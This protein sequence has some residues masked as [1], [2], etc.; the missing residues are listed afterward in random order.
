MRERSIGYEFLRE[1]L[2]TPA[3]PLNRAARVSP[4]T[5]VTTMA[6]TLAVPAS[7]APTN[8]S[9]LEHLQFAL[10]HEGMQLQAAILA[11]KHIQQRDVGIAFNASPSSAYLRQICFLWELANGTPLEGLPAAS[12]P[13]TPLFDPAKFITGPSRR[14]TRWRV[15]FNGLGTT[16]YCPTVRR[17]PEIQALLDKN[18][19]GSASTFISSLDK[20]VLDRAV[21][22]AYLSETQGSYAIENETPSHSKTEAFAALLSRAHAPEHITEEYL[23]ALQNLTVSNPLDKAVQFRTDQNWLRNA[24][25]GAMG[26]TYLPPPPDL[27]MPLMDQIMNMANMTDHGIDPLVLGSLVSF[28]FVF[29]HPFMDG[30]GRLSRFLFHKLV[31]SC[32]QL[33]NGLV[34]PISIAMKRHEEQYLQA[35]QTFSKPARDLWQVTTIDDVRIDA[36]FK[37]DASNY[38]YWDATPCVAFGLQMASEALNHDLRE[39]SEFL[40]RFDIVYSAVNDAVDMNNND[41]ILLVR[42]CLQNGGVLSNNRKKQLIAKGHPVELLDAAQLAVTTALTS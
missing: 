31:C 4:V 9:P 6:D 10:K 24:L 19:L 32:S 27:M 15:D 20:S 25:P 3:F 26:V 14:N 37:G 29:A 42:A 1:T 33:P 11:L 40:K 36:V 12:G 13:Y 39:E 30:N 23:V 5:K 7:V 34:L 35:L 18:I 41:L 21:R 22:W 16:S 17:T 38:C 28:G 8:E 2:G